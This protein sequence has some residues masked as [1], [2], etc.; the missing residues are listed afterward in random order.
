[1]PKPNNNPTNE[2]HNMVNELPVEHQSTENKPIIEIP[3]S[4]YDKLAREEAEIRQKQ[5]EE[6]N[7]YICI[8]NYYCYSNI[9]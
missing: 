3:Q 1:M 7:S 4:Y 2:T 5:Q 6:Q 8:F 9:L